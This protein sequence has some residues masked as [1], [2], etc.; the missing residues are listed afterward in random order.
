[1][2]S[3]I[4]EDQLILPTIRNYVLEGSR[5]NDKVPTFSA[6]NQHKKTPA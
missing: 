5:G 2:T 6:N 3:P 4:G 1:M